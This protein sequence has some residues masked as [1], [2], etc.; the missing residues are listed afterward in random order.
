M[1]G[2]NVNIITIRLVGE[3]RVNLM[4]KFIDWIF[5]SRCLKDANW[6]N[7]NKLICRNCGEILA[8]A[9]M[10][11][12]K[13]K[14]AFMPPYEQHKFRKIIEEKYF[15]LLDKNNVKGTTELEVEKLLSELKSLKDLPPEENYLLDDDESI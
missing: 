8:W 6:D 13:V 1:F 9:Y 3:K 2:G 14:L 12:G 4:I 5:P 10:W 11:G 7:D 15:P